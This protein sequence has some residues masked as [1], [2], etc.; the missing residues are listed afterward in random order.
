LIPTL[1]RLFGIDLGADGAS[2]VAGAI[3]LGVQFGGA[4]LAI[5]GRFRATK[6]LDMGD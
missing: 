4:I 5:Y 3:E 1:L 6:R 2:L